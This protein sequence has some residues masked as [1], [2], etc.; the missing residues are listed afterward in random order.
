MAAPLLFLKIVKGHHAKHGGRRG[1][2]QSDN[3]YLREGDGDP[4]RK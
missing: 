4:K 1:K 3:L 2:Q